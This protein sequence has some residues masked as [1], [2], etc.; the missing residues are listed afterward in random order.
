[1]PNLWKIRKCIVQ[2]LHCKNDRRELVSKTGNR[3]WSSN[4]KNIGWDKYATRYIQR[5]VPEKQV[6]NPIAIKGG[7]QLDGEG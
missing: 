2:I 4:I 5:Q 6:S 3:P 1:M 7:D